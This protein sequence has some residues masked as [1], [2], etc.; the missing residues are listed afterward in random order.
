MVVRAH[1]GAKARNM[2][3]I[4]KKV[5]LLVIFILLLISLAAVKISE[6][7][8][9]GKK[10]VFIKDNSF[11]VELAETKQEKESGL[12]FRESLALDSGMLFIYNDEERR[13][14]YMKNTYIPLDIIWVDKEKKAV[15]IKKDARPG[16]SNDYETVYP[17]E[18]AMYVLELNS[19]ASDKAG[20]EVGDTLQF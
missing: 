18:K 7:L 2:D 3:S 13:S 10:Q 6:S 4:Y 9:G 8:A 5:R 20:L 19:G 14:F 16:D 1:L 11:F 17:Q 15:F 12:M